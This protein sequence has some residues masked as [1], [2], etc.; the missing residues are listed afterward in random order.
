MTDVA[1]A[2]PARIRIAGAGY[3]YAGARRRALDGIDLEV[4]AGT[5]V[6]IVGPNGAGKSTLC[7]VASGLAPVV[8]GGEL[9]GSVT[10]GELATTSQ[11]PHELAQRCGVLFQDPAAQLSGT[12]VT[13]FEELAFGPRNLGLPLGEVVGRVRQSLDVL[14]I[15]A[16][17]DRDPAHLSGGQAQ[18]VA[19]AA[20]LAL[21]PAFLVL[22]EPTS[23]LDPEGTRIVGDALADLAR[24]TGCGILVAEHKTAL[25]ERLADRVVLIDDGR[26]VAS[27]PATVLLADPVLGRH[28]VEAPP[29]VRV[30]AALRAAG[31][32]LP[33]P[34]A[35]ILS[36]SAG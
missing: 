2:R 33:E 7:L 18:L 15:G 19:L 27:G 8:V 20:I 23:Q 36:G 13:V 32:S 1:A 6:G 30:A 11:R 28:G 12:A 17:A 26:V 3:R 29:R 10:I 14:G 4:E 24:T 34:V 21:R 16:L 35:A 25:L 5:V 9:E 22:D 31:I